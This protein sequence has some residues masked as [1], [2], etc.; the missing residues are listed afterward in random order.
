MEINRILITGGCGFLG[1]HVIEHLLKTTDWE[2]VILDCLTYAGNL[3][4]LTDIEE[5]DG[6]RVKFVWHDLR[7]PISE[8]THKMIG[9][10]DYIWHIAAESHVEKSLQ[11][12]VPFAQSNVLGTT[13]LLEYVK[14]YQPNLK[15]YIGFNTDE[16]FGAAEPGIFH[17][18]DTKFYPS[19]PYA[20]AKA[21]Q[22]CMEYAFGHSFGLPI[23]LTHTMN[24]FGERQ[25][26]EKFVPLA[27]NSILKGEKVCLH[28]SPDNVS[29]RCWIHARS[30]ADALLFVNEQKSGVYSI[31]GPERD[32]L[33]LANRICQVIKGRDLQEEEIDWVDF[34]KT[35]P[36]HDLRYS[37]DGSKIKNMGFDY[38]FTFE[39]SFDKTIKWILDNKKWSI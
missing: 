13:N 17:T 32:V 18:E 8:T 15:R 22:W 23:T 4:R 11:D 20:A 26:P 29:S 25:H 35:R 1:H 24:I 39:E 9:D 37:L 27:V 31:V 12:A 38:K 10:V 16:V 19:N 30:V 21:G 33:Y 6:S 5:F 3:N 34:H 36:G 14:H 2:I 28:G 7:A